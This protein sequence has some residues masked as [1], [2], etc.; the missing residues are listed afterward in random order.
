[1][2]KIGHSRLKERR[3]ER[4]GQRKEDTNRRVFQLSAILKSSVITNEL[5]KIGKQEAGRQSWFRSHQFLSLQTI[6]IPAV[7]VPQLLTDF[8]LHPSSV[9]MIM[10][11]NSSRGQRHIKPDCHLVH[12]QAR[13][14][15]NQIDEEMGS[16][17]QPATV[18]LLDVHIVQ[19]PSKQLCLQPQSWATRHTAQ[20]S[21]FCDWQQSMQRPKTG[22]HAE[23]NNL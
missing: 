23:A 17:A 9:A 12:Y 4:L 11:C 3:L 18:T 1:M 10:L 20:G 8:L 21:G 7:D 6:P 19:L 13:L 16:G 22:Q 5:C 2:S 15:L 14:A